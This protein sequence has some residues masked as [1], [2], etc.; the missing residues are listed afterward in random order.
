[1]IIRSGSWKFVDPSKK[2]YLG[3]KYENNGKQAHDKRCDYCGVY[4]TYDIKNIAAWRENVKLGHDGWPE[5]V[6]C[7][8]TCCVE[9]HR[10]VQAHE[11]NQA[12]RVVDYNQGLFTKLKKQGVVV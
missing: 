3:Y 1:M 6:H 8:S 7:G 10:R 12:K 9:Y 11:A 2:P 4:M 5:K